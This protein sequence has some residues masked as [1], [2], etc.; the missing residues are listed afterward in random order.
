MDTVSNVTLAEI[1][2]FHLNM[3]DDFKDTMQ[4]FLR[5]QIDFHKKLTEKLEQALQAYDSV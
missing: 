4:T 5:Q 1:N 3:K 2:Q